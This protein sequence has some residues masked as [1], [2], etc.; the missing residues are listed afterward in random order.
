MVGH[1]YKPNDR[2]QR[3]ADLSGS[4]LSLPTLLGEF[5][6]TERLCLRNKMDGAQG[7]PP[8][9]AVGLYGHHAHTYT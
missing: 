2:G 6:A 1:A 7:T 4:L 9:V 5:Q 8:E 3:Q